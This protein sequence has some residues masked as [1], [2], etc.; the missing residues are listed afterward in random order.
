MNNRS[1]KMAVILA[2]GRGT[3]LV[4]ITDDRPKCLV[5]VAGKP[6]LEHQLD[7]Y[8]RAGYEMVRIV[9][10]Y[11]AE[12]I[13]AWLQTR[14][15]RLSI[16]VIDN[17]SFAYSN[18]MVSF[19]LARRG[20]CHGFTLSNGDVVF[21]PG[22]IDALANEP[23]SQSLIATDVGRWT[24]EAMKLA[25][26]PDGRPAAIS[27]LIGEEHAL[28]C[29]TDLYRVAPADAQRLLAEVAARVGRAERGDWLEVALDAVLAR[30]GHGFRP[31]PIGGHP[32]VEIDD[33]T[34]LLAA[35]LLFSRLQDRPLPLRCAVIDIDGTLLLG[36]VAIPGARQAV[37]LLRRLGL[38]IVFCTNNSAQAPAEIAQALDALG[39]DAA[40]GDVVSS[41]DATIGYLAARGVRGLMV[42]GT[43]ALKLALAH[44]GFSPDAAAPELVVIGFDRSLTF[45]TA[46][47][48]CQLI[49]AGTPYILTH[50]DVSCPTPEGPVPDAGAI[51][52]MLEAATGRRPDA[53]L[54]KPSAWMAAA[55]LQRGAVAASQTVVI[56][57]RSSTDIRMGRDS[58]C[59]T[60]L[61]LSGATTRADVERCADRPDLIVADIGAFARRLEGEMASNPERLLPIY[62]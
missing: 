14:S 50:G 56:G 5:T 7:A 45:A 18:N 17:Q 46:A 23:G 19:H 25:L 30:G 48:A 40:P 51:G 8:D 37:A 57:D 44:A 11:R 49:A 53:V 26:G 60:V 1:R 27:K 22:L 29:S 36:R 55:A 15:W 38:R 16:E 54:G 2:A 31:F 61:V 4:P 13:R 12:D 10:G 58:G 33:L 34:D 24:G 3:R 9:A 42:L 39:F 43:P 41:V 35:D 28:G 52:A 62:G 6:I 32:W 47:R 20:L 59:G 21:G